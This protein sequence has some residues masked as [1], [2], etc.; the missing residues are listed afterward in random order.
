GWAA[1]DR[2]LRSIVFTAIRN[3]PVGYWRGYFGRIPHLFGLGFHYDHAGADTVYGYSRQMLDRVEGPRVR[4][5]RN[6]VRTRAWDVVVKVSTVLGSIVVVW[7]LLG[8][9][10]RPV[11]I[12]VALLTLGSIAFNDATARFLY[13]LVPLM[14]CFVR[15][16]TELRMCFPRDTDRGFNGGMFEPR[17]QG[18]DR[19]Q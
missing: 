1:A 3:D 17:D 8:R 9:P 6:A 16:P 15:S 7:G 5:G 13:P 2:E 14:L 19:G 12:V 18:E 10:P 4:P 11:W